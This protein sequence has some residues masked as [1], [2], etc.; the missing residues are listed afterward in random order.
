MS[1]L[2]ERVRLGGWGGWW[3]GG[4]DVTEGLKGRGRGCEV[5]YPGSVRGQ[6]FGGK[7]QKEGWAQWLTPVIP[8]LSEAETGGSLEP[9]SSRPAWVT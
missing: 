4:R 8:A 6:G 7:R 2:T 5:G 1:P 9:W 3:S